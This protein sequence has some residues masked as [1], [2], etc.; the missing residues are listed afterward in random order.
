MIGDDLDAYDDL[1][2]WT[3]SHL[4]PQLPAPRGPQPPR[5]AQGLR[6]GGPS[7]TRAQVRYWCSAGALAGFEQDVEQ[8]LLDDSRVVGEQW[9]DVAMGLLRRL[10]V[11]EARVARL[12][13][14]LFE[15]RPVRPRRRRW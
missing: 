2:A 1:D 10:D 13:R 3:R 11:T 6:A 5:V 9:E 7:F 12:E 14:K 4:A 8:C 15:V